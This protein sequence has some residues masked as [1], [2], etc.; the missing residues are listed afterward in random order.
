MLSAVAAGAF[1]AGLALGW[2]LTAAWLGGERQAAS[3]RAVAAE[4]IASDATAEAARWKA[5]AAA[6]GER[7]D[8]EGRARQAVE[9]QLAATLAALPR[10]AGA[11]MLQREQDE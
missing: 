9:A 4:R 2:R 10:G 5:L 1:L 3:A 11:K 8:A 6:S 7:A